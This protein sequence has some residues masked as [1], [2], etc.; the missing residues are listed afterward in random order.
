MMLSSSANTI[1]LL[2][3]LIALA[4]LSSCCWAASSSMKL[5]KATYDELTPGKTVFIKFFAPWCGHCK[6]LAPAWVKLSREWESNRRRDG[7]GLVGEIDCTEEEDW[8]STEWEI[9][10]FPTLLYGDPSMGG[11]FLETYEGD[12]SYESLSEFANTTLSGPVCS[13]TN[14]DA[15]EESWMKNLL[16]E[17]WKS[18]LSVLNDQIAEKEKSIKDAKTDFGRHFDK[19]QK[20]YD[21]LS[22]NHQ[23]DVARKKAD[24]KV[25]KNL[26]LSKL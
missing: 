11:I 22:L 15:C 20:E 10:A 12:K 2:E 26:L 16:T 6:E 9:T 25:L 23:L 14:I 24:L 8:C 18:S 1:L 13:P 7:V 19:M 5:T 17:A 4:F 3:V 21:R